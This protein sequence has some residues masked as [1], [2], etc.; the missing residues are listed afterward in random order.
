VHTEFKTGN[1]K[2][3]DYLRDFYCRWEDN[4]KIGLGRYSFAVRMSAGFV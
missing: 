3:T 4:I 2:G 1:V